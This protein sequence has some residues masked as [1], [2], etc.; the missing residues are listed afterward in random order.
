MEAL[1]FGAGG[2]DGHYLSRLC[3]QRG[4]EVA[5]VSRRNAAIIGDV[6]DT[7]FVAQLIRQRR[8]DFVFHLAANSTTRHDAAAENH[9]TI[10]A[11]TLNIL[12]AV[13][14]HSPSSRVF[15]AGSALQF[16]NRGEAIAETDPFE[17]GSPYAA[18]RI[19]SNYLARYYR[20][21]ECGCFSGIFSITKVRCA[22]PAM[23]QGPSRKPRAVRER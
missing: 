11:G 9:A 8:P 1:I 3:R 14:R 6:A 7:A 23:W 21:I 5:A 16:A 20:G 15:L 13:H 10:G 19:Y 12:D 22:S 17:A 2:Q 18:A 4:M